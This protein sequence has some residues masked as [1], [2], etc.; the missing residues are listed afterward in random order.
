MRGEAF[1]PVSD[2]YPE[3]TD[4]LNSIAYRI[5]GSRGYTSGADFQGNGTNWYEFE[6]ST[7]LA[8]ELRTALPELEAVR[9]IETIPRQWDAPVWWPGQ[10]PAN[11]KIYKRYHEYLV[12]PDSGTRAWFLRIR[13]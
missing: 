12:L 6:V 11:A 10:W 8:D 7:D 9:L 13:V 5:K 2:R 1:G 4:L 3:H